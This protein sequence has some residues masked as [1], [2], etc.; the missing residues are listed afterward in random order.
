MKRRC[1]NKDFTHYKDYGGRGISIEK[2]WHTFENFWEDMGSGYKDDLTL[3][4]IDNSG[5]YCKENCVWAT[6]DQQNA[7]KRTTRFVHLKGKDYP[8]FVLAKKYNMHIHT[9]RSRLERGMS[10]EEA[11]KVPVKKTV[12]C[13]SYDKARDKWKAIYKSKMI[14]RFDTKVE[15][16]E[17]LKKTLAKTP[18]H[19]QTMD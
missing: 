18:P 1:L 10:P 9:L 5:N 2:R 3:E 17:A 19:T 6:A 14:G 11:I 8:L 15:A 7:N 4:R 16:G 13:I 12:G